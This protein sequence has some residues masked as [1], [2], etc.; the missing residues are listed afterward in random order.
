VF[1]A[2]LIIAGFCVLISLTTAYVQ[3]LTNCRREWAR[4]VIRA[5]YETALSRG[6]ILK[7]KRTEIQ[8]KI[9]K[10]ENGQDGGTGY[11]PD[12]HGGIERVDLKAD[13]QRNPNISSL[14]FTMDGQPIKPST[15]EVHFRMACKRAKLV[16]EKHVRF[17]DL[18]HTRI[19]IW[20]FSGVPTA[21]A[22]LAAGHKSVTSHKKYQNLSEQDAMQVSVF[23]KC[24]NGPTEK[25]SKRRVRQ[26]HD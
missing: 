23:E 1:P 14:A 21:S 9:I 8:E 6:D 2:V 19:T 17:H 12:S 4:R 7:M 5:A 24:L 18:R 15:F 25:F 20:A 3:L 13:W 26:L 11:G 22:M 16:E 10:L